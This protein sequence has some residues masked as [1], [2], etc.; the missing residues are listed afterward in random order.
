MEDCTASLAGTGF[1]AQGTALITHYGLSAPCILRLS[2]YAAHYLDERSYSA[3]LVMNWLGDA[4]EGDAADLLHSL[5]SANR[6]KLVCNTHPDFL[7][8]RH[9]EFLLSRAGIS[10]D[11]R[12]NAIGRKQY[13]RLASVLTSDRYQIIGRVPHKEEF[14]TAGGVSLRSVAPSTLEC[15][16]PLGFILPGKSLMWTV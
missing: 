14:V 3:P 5:A 4:N 15:K 2:S 13:N 7:T 9:W 12:W 6:Q 1:R 10:N 11:M 8:S 16:H